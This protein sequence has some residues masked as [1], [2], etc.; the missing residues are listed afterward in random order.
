MLTPWVEV[1]DEKKEE[2]Y[3]GDEFNVPPKPQPVNTGRDFSNMLADYNAA[4]LIPGA[5]PTI[6]D[7]RD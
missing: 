4:A 6:H 2:D 5:E 7:P 3:C 1:D